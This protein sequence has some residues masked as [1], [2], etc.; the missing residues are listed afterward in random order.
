LT[1]RPSWAVASVRSGV[2]RIQT[3]R[4]Y[5]KGEREGG[6]EGGRGRASSLGYLRHSFLTA[7]KGREGRREGGR[8]GGR[9]GGRLSRYQQRAWD[10][11]IS[12]L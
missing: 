4:M 10:A 12:R 8:E 5:D 1:S 2:E 7:T 6:R 3:T 9:V 11:K